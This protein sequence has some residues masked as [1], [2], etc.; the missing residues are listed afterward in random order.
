[1]ARTACRHGP[2][3]EPGG[4]QAGL[5]GEDH[6]LHPVAQA[7]LGQDPGHV[8][9]HR[10]LTERE[11]AGD[12]GVAHAAG[13]QPQHLE[14]ARRQYGQVAVRRAGRPRLPGE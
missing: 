4:D 2:A 12:L 5:V 8:G 1:V 10:R 13:D 14:L 11:R 3:R 9:L 7:E 6:S